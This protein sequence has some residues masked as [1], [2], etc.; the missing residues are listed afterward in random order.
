[1][2]ALALGLY[3]VGLLAVFGVR[4]WLHRRRTGS[5]GFHGISGPRGSLSWWAG[6]AFA[7]ALLLQLLAALLAL[8]EV[9]PAPVEPARIA[10]SV[11]VAGLVLAVAG[12]MGTLA[13]QAA[14]GVSWRIGVDEDERTKLITSGVFAWVRNPVFTAMVTAQLGVGLMVPTVLS[15]A[16]VALLVL[17]VQLQVRG[18]E[19]PYLLRTHGQ[20]YASYA[21]RT[22]RFLPAL[23]RMRSTGHDHGARGE[24]R[25]STSRR[26]DHHYEIMETT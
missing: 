1:M 16:A 3:L 23:G 6:I 10:R 25:R 15:L 5:S 7:T 8:L 19:E 21:A 12:L 18:T 11:G 22:G 9:L 2:T 20:H 14:M 26:P 17:A 24:G 13:A 4:T